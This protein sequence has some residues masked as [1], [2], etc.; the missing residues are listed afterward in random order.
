MTPH[1]HCTGENELALWYRQAAADWLEALPIGNGRLGAMVFG[2]VDREHLQI[3]EDTLWSGWPRENDNKDGAKSLSEIRQLIMEKG[4]YLAGDELCKKLQGPFNESYQPLGDLYLDMAHEGPV[5]DYRRA[6]DLHTATAT[7]EYRVGDALFR[8]EVFATAVD[9][10]IAI[11]LTTDKPGRLSFMVHMDSPHP[12]ALLSVAPNRASLQGRCPMHVVPSY[13][14]QTKE[15]V[16]YEQGADARGTRFE[17]QVQV[18]V[19][20]GAWWSDASGLHIEQADAA[21][22]LLAAFSS[23]RGY[24]QDPSRDHRQVADLSAACA[25]TLSHVAERP[26]GRLLEEHIADYRR[27]FDRVVL[28]LGVAGSSVLPTDD[29]VRAARE[30]RAD[31]QLAAL[32]FQF[33]RYL[34]IA[35][36]RPGTQAA[37]LQ[38]IWNQD[39]RPM[40][41]CNYTTNIN[42][43]MNYWP[44]E[45]CNL[46]ECH[47]P[48]FDLIQETSVSGSE[49]ARRIYGCQGWVAHHNVDAWRNGWAVGDGHLAT[50]YTIWPMGG[51]WLCQHLWEHYAFTGDKQFLEQRAYPLMRG[52]ATFMLDCLVEDGAGHL[53]TCPSTSPENTFFL[54]DGRPC[55]VGV[56]STMDMTIVYDLFTNCIE[57]SSALGRDAL[58]RSE[59]ER[60]RERLLPLQIG[61]HGQLQEYSSD[62]DEPEI[63][64]RHHSHLYG[65]FPGRQ[66]TPSATP[67]LA[68]ACARSLDRR[69]EHGAARG[70]W[71]CAWTINLWARLGNAERA[72]RQVQ[73]LVG[74]ST[75]LNLFNGPRVYQIDGNLGGTAGIAEMLLQSHAGE[76]SLLPALPQAWPDGCVQGLCARGG[77]VVDITWANGSMVKVEVKS[78]LGNVCRLRTSVPVEVKTGAESVGVRTSG[79][80]LTEFDTEPNIVYEVTPVSSA[81]ARSS[82]KAG[83]CAQIRG[84]TP[85][86]RPGMT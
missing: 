7:V 31:P 21:T 71:P 83:K 59:L 45:V 48:L 68:E 61:K 80:Y 63:G 22:V 74:K 47:E 30:G 77:F 25:G 75:Y 2:G 55:A 4:D 14:Q 19:E 72:Y 35:S 37:N 42:T 12:H 73:L 50:M 76:I 32:Y 82:Q 9:Q 60:A 79:A 53:V 34:L 57:A 18:Q 11:R 54:P 38:G 40:W 81:P 49:T 46:S 52:A 26:Y 24:D 5:E 62:F 67:E 58:F 78:K 27:L 51:A 70:A 65:L 66:I 1:E 10:V 3:N 20:G 29:R 6:L 56:G 86:C 39:V 41:S 8:R 69:Y 33:G 23:H 17:A 43:Q 44:A 16:V 28:S 15:P 13:L 84:P 64:H 36:S 85:A